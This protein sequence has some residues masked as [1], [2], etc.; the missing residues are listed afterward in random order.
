M[1]LASITYPRI[2]PVLFRLGPFAVRWYGLAYVTGFVLGYL[3]LRKM[4]RRGVLRLVPDALGDLVT[5]MAAGVIIGGRSGWWLFYHR[6]TGAAEAL[7]GTD[8]HLARRHE[9]PRRVDRRRARP[10]TLDLA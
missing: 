9:L 7:V 4:I 6:G 5:W 3:I 2:D 8:R 1:T 10:D